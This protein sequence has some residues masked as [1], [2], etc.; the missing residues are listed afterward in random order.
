MRPAV[1]MAIFLCIYI[2]IY[3]EVI[4]Q[5]YVSVYYTDDVL[6]R[7][8]ALLLKYGNVFTKICYRKLSSA[9]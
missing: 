4:F 3:Y 2:Y 1:D 9:V 6:N 8:L 7:W 5:L